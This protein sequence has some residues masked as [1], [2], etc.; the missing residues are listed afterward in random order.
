MGNSGRLFGT[1]M[2]CALMAGLLCV[3]DSAFA[4]TTVTW[5]PTH[6]AVYDLSIPGSILVYHNEVSQ[7]GLDLETDQMSTSSAAADV[8][9]D[10][11]AS[12]IGARSVV[13]LGAVSFGSVSSIPDSGYSDET[14]A[15]PGHVYIVQTHSHGFAKV[16]IESITGSQVALEYAL[17]SASGPSS[18]G[19]GTNRGGATVTYDDMYTSP[20]L[21]FS[22][23]LSQGGY[24]FHRQSM[25]NSSSQADVVF[26]DYGKTIGARSV[27]DMGP[28][29]FQKLTSIPDYGSTLLRVL[30]KHVYVIRTHD[31]KYVKAYV[32]SIL[33]KEVVFVYATMDPKKSRPS[34]PSTKDIRQFLNHTWKLVVPGSSYSYDNYA[35]NTRT[36]VSSVGALAGHLYLNSNGHYTWTDPID[37][38]MKGVWKNTSNP[39]WPI[40][41]V[42]GSEHH[43][44]KLGRSSSSVWGGGDIVIWDG[45]TWENGFK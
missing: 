12:T 2:A 45:Y 24:S 18:S 44:W 20:V 1:T 37:G 23:P 4:K 7:G 26:G 14:R 31:H 40:V 41:L 35:T 28:V 11:Q 15:V 9:F 16:L 38:T 34:N 33:S 10:E 42:N 29:N 22:N 13:D 36:T 25:T 6:T 21:L 5:T 3:P 30:P 39:D 32:Q 19:G 17:V 8:A 27:T 43:I